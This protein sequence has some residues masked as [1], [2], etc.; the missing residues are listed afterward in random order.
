MGKVTSRLGLTRLTF[1]PYS[2]KQLQ[3]I[4]MSRLNGLD[5]FSSDAVQLVARKVAALSGDAR[6][7]LDICRRAS[8]IA[9]GDGKDEKASVSMSHV[10]Q[11]LSEMISC[12]KVK[13]V[14]AC[15]KME[16]LFLQA[17]CMEVERTGIEEVTFRGVFNQLKALSTLNGVPIPSTETALGITTR[18]G[19]SRLLICE[20]SRKDIYMK[21]LLNISADDFYYATQLRHQD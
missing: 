9:E 18:L 7:A 20:H 5:S 3:E 14:K 10:Q 15:S 8:E 17:V 6:R 12:T 13:A 1:Q 11:A 19:S 4:V 21:I 16:K 2:H